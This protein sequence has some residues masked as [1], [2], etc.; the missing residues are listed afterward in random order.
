MWLVQVELPWACFGFEVTSD[1][2]I[3]EAAPNAAWTVGKRGRAGGAS[4]PAGR[5]R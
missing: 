4:A 2:W 1:G 5:G 3:I